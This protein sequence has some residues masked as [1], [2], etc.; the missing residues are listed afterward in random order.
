MS[1]FRKST[2]QDSRLSSKSPGE[3]RGKPK[4]KK[5]SI[6]NKREARGLR[7]DAGKPSQRLEPRNN[8]GMGDKRANPNNKRG[9]RAG[10]MRRFGE[11]KATPSYGRPRQDSNDRPSYG[12]PRQDSNDRPSY[13]RPRQDSN[14]RP[15]YGRPRQDSN[16]RPSYGRPRQDSNDRPSYGRPRQDSNDRPS[17]G[18]P[19]Q[20]SNDRPNYGRPRSDSDDRPR[21]AQRGRKLTNRAQGLKNTSQGFRK[22]S[23]ET[24]DRQASGREPF[25]T[26]CDNCGKDCVVPFKPTGIKPVFCSDCHR[27]RR[28]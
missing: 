6:R 2:R 25:A 23:R 27:K 24:K 14:D 15:S 17:Y 18:R 5:E 10:P 22:F 21:E 4:S 19:R 8:F 20:D 11:E 1:A 7:E 13:G 16:D 9:G 3:R 26:Q 28:D 12:R